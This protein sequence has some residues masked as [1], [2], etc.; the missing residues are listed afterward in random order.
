MVLVIFIA[1]LCRE[2]HN[3]LC[4]LPHDGGTSPVK[5]LIRYDWNMGVQIH[6]LN[7]SAFVRTEVLEKV[8]AHIEVHSDKF[9]WRSGYFHS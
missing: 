8:V 2:L 7:V 5:Y 9:T 4:I 1:Y 3:S 6:N